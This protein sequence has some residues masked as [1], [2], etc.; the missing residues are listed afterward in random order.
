[1]KKAEGEQWLQAASIFTRSPSL[2]A[3]ESRKAWNFQQ[4]QTS[5]LLAQA[6]PGSSP[7]QLV[8]T[9]LTVVDLETLHLTL[10]DMENITMA[11][12]KF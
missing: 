8:C 11:S 5:G 2:R 9:S 10:G 3:S 12:L 7:L 6:K 4:D 1:M